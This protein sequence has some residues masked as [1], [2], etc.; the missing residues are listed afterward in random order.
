MKRHYRLHYLARVHTYKQLL[1]PASSCPLYRVTSNK[2]EHTHTY[3]RRAALYNA[4]LPSEPAAPRTPSPGFRWRSRPS[5]NYVCRCTATPVVVQHFPNVSDRL[6]QTCLQ[7]TP[8]Q[9]TAGCLLSTVTPRTSRLGPLQQNAAP[10]G[11][12]A[13]D[14]NGAPGACALGITREG[15]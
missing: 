2:K 5:T 14:F 15:R 6:L 8:A 3:C 10:R 13:V 7:R 12:N 1:S 4:G 11:S 9:Y